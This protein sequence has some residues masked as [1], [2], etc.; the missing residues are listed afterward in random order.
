MKKHIGLLVFCLITFPS[1]AQWYVAHPYIGTESGPFFSDIYFHNSSRGYAC[2][3]YLQGGPL[4]P[5]H[6]CIAKTVDGGSS[7]EYMIFDSLTVSQFRPLSVSF[8]N[9]T[10]GFLGGTGW[11]G[12]MMFTENGGQSWRWLNSFPNKSAA[13]L[14]IVNDSSLACGLT[15]FDS[16]LAVTSNRGETW[17]IKDI[18]RPSKLFMDDCFWGL[19]ATTGTIGTSSNDCGDTFIQH[20]F[21]DNVNSGGRISIWASQ[22]KVYA[23]GSI[24]EGFANIATIWVSNDMG[25]TFDMLIFEGFQAVS[26][27]HPIS[28][29]VAFASLQRVFPADDSL[30]VL[31]KTIDG[32]QSWHFQE[33]ELT[34]SMEEPTQ[35]IPPTVQKMIC[36]HPDTCIALCALSLIY[37]TFNGGGPLLDPVGQTYVG[38]LEQ[39]SAGLGVYPNP[40][41]DVLFIPSA[42][43]NACSIVL[44]ALGQVVWQGTLTNGTLPLDQFHSGTYVLSIDQRRQKFVVCK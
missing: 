35:S 14:E 26:D 22:Q 16:A 10:L 12:K 31:V 40:A 43:P 41:S 42:E 29:Q 27:L 39:K 17:T 13:F 28:E 36:P 37:R 30:P 25:V 11:M 8:L 19:G 34:F 6:P 32:G 44:D 38:V 23:Y 15:S 20:A 24:L 18:Y 33:H 2:G 3:M 1:V 21:T 4:A 7:F 5:A 9:D